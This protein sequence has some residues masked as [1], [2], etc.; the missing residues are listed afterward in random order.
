MMFYYE[1]RKNVLGMHKKEVQKRRL[2]L[3]TNFDEPILSPLAPT[4]LLTGAQE[5][6]YIQECLKSIVPYI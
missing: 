6:I 3:S 1:E 5:S 4:L 2:L